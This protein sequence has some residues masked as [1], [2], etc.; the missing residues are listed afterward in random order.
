MEDVTVSIG[1]GSFYVVEE[2]R[3]REDIPGGTYVAISSGAHFTPD[4]LRTFAYE[5][6]ERAADGAKR[7]ELADVQVD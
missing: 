1:C 4:E 7:A 5:L 2:T 3:A 6:I